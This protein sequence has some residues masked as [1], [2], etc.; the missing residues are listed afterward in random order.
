M[1]I[2]KTS[3]VAVHVHIIQDKKMY[4][5]FRQVPWSMRPEVLKDDSVDNPIFMEIKRVRT[6]QAKAT[7]GGQTDFNTR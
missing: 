7:P 1:G 4:H 2:L 6:G 5:L 3:C